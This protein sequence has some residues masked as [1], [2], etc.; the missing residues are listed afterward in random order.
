ML[1]TS[2]AA[3]GVLA[4]CGLPLAAFGGGSPGLQAAPPAQAESG[5]A[6]DKITPRSPIRHVVIIYQENHSFDDVLGGVCRKRRTPCNGY[7]GPVRF[8]DGKRATNV[9]QPDIVPFVAHNRLSQRLA[10]RNRWNEMRGCTGHIH[11]CVSHV[12][13]RRIPN[14]AA[15]ARK[16][17]VSDATFA[18][19]ASASFGEHLAL[20]TGTIGG[21]VGSIP[22][23]S[24]T[25]AK[26]LPGWGCR[27]RKD[28]LWHPPAGG[29]TRYVPA[30]IPDS[31]GRG[32]YRH[33]P[34]RYRASV[35]QRLEAAGLSWH[36]Y[37]G[38]LRTRPSNGLW[39][40]CPNLF[41]CQSHRY[42][43]R[44]DSAARDFTKAAR[45][46]RLRSLS[47]LMPMPV[48]SQHNHN[49][50][51]VGD[52]YIGRMVN[53]AQHGPQWRHTA[54]FITYDDCG[55]F[56]DHV[57]PPGG[58]GIRNPMVIVSPWAKRSFTDSRTAV[59]PYS[60]LAFIQHNFHLGRLSRHVN[61][62]YDYRH[63][64]DFNQRPLGP[65]KLTHSHISDRERAEL[66]S[67]PNG[68]RDVT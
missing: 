47:L 5:P 14:L 46:G 53:A 44:Y 48:N 37:Q 65:A 10:L 67:L 29:R 27:S 16:Y 41:W 62:A 56:Y 54:I 18:S 38:N 15:L 55:C 68:E 66:A 34:V 45:A 51:R 23:P 58:L 36:I 20:A 26:P 4:A 49:S 6:A 43:L 24:V 32:P 25:G 9:V 19:N 40:I 1:R 50:M 31:H 22:V 61:H 21:W 60:M 3:I 11:M 30:C 28:A 64:F 57:N 13:P 42:R 8:R 35:M 59:Q 17:A 2:F 12:P 63:V 33:S 39:S 52:N 7:T